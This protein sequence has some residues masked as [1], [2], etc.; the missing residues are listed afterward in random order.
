MS[1][2]NLCKV[3]SEKYPDR[4]ATWLLG[5]EYSNSDIKVL[6]A[7]LSIEPIRA[8]SVTLLRTKDQILHI[9]FQVLVASKPP[10][11]LRLLDYWVRLYRQYG[12]PIIQIAILLKP[13]K[14]E[15]EDTFAVGTTRH[16][17]Q[18]IKMWEQDPLPLLQDEALLPLAVLTATT[19]P[20][21]LL[22]QVDT[23]ISR[24]E[25]VDKRKDVAA[26]AKIMAGLRYKKTLIEGLFRE[27]M[28]RESVIYQD[29]LQEGR[30]EGRQVGLQEG[31]QVGLQ[32]GRQVGLQE[33]AI[34]LVLRQLNRK[35][36]VLDAQV[37]DRISNLGITQLEDLAEALLEFSHLS[38]LDN[39]LRSLS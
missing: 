23:A 21:Q 11:P 12:V 4:F 30:Q 29:I 1:Y 5:E 14:Q 19:K 22:E 27:P 20:T 7:E 13:T 33:E 34:A 15:V 31:R 18:I 35:I 26:C 8:D 38:D 9:E 3:L 6:K 17:F 10:L 25:E 28:M 16:S 36:G 2:D 39:W 32:E 37:V 24:I